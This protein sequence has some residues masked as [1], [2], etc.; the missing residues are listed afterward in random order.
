MTKE[1]EV[2][3]WEQL[4][5]AEKVTVTEDMIDNRDPCETWLRIPGYG[6]FVVDPVELLLSMLENNAVPGRYREQIA[7]LID[8]A[9][10]AECE[11]N[12]SD[13]A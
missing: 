4:N 3:I 6:L 10:D 2:P 11:E 13:E 1:N 5:P 12:E 7:S 8:E 9:I